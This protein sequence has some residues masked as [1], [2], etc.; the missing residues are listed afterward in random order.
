MVLEYTPVRVILYSLIHV[1]FGD[2]FKLY[3][4]LFLFVRLMGE[5]IQFF[6]NKYD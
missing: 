2:V 5:C 4:L 3:S 6:I 1:Y